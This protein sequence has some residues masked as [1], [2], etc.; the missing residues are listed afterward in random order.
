M[1]TADTDKGTRFDSTIANPD[2]E[3]TAAWLGTRKK[4]SCGH[5]HLGPIPSAPLI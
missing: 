1:V 3:L 2:I 4:D 5:D